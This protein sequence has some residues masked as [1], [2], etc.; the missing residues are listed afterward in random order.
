MNHFLPS[1]N[2]WGNTWKNGLISIVTCTFSGLRVLFPLS[3]LLLHTRSFLVSTLCDYTQ[4]WGMGRG[5][6]PR[7][8]SP[9]WLKVRDAQFELRFPGRVGNTDRCRVPVP[10]VGKRKPYSLCPSSKSRKLSYTIVPLL[11]NKL[12][13]L[14]PNLGLPGGSAVKD[15]PANAGDSAANA[16][17]SA[18]ISGSGRYPWRKKWKLPLVFLPGESH[19][20]RSLVGYSLLRL[21]KSGTRLRRLSG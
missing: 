10:T 1:F 6:T 16:G 18:L 11:Q 21:Q 13:L 4:K 5:L 7:F 9:R 14:N 15:R 17:D 2:R 20:Q 19:G 8:L 3:M 12:L